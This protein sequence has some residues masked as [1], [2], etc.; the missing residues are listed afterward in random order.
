M[1]ENERKPRWE[2]RLREEAEC[3]ASGRSASVKL[4][5]AMEERGEKDG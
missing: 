2:R 5:A 3:K 4:E 1:L